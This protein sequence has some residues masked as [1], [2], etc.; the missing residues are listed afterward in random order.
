M[1]VLVSKGTFQYCLQYVFKYI[2]IYIYGHRFG[3]HIYIY[4]IYYIMNMCG[5]C[6]VRVSEFLGAWIPT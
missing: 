2:Y 4:I 1:D 6:T 3:P 5:G